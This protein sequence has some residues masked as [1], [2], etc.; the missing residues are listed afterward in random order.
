MKAKYTLKDDISSEARDLLTRLL[1][2]DPNKRITIAE[3]LDHKWLSDVD[4]SIELFT[5]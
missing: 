4:E 5:E 2:K 1:E 3:I